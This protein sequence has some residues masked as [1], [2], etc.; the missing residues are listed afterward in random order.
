ISKPYSDTSDP[1]AAF[2]FVTVAGGAP[3]ANDADSKILMASI[4]SGTAATP[5]AVGTSGISP[6]LPVAIAHKTITASV[7]VT[8][9]STTADS[10]VVR[11]YAG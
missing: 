3:A 6:V 4:G 9:L 5:A 10:T 2:S 1:N 11:L 8:A 7:A